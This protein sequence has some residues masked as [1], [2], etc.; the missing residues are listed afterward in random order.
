MQSLIKIVVIKDQM[1]AF[2]WSLLYSTIFEIIKTFI[3]NCS[4]NVFKKKL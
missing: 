3:Y 4:V 1:K 2:S